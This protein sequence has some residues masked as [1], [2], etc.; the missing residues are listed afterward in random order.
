MSLTS[1]GRA[2]VALPC[3]SHGSRAPLFVSLATRNAGA[4]LP[5]V[6]FRCPVIVAMRRSV[7]WF[8]EPGA[9]WPSAYLGPS[10]S[11]DGCHDDATMTSSGQPVVTHTAALP[12]SRPD[13][14]ASCRATRRPARPSAAIP[15][16]SGSRN[17]LSPTSVAMPTIIT[18]HKE[19]DVEEK[20][21]TSNA[22]TEPSHDAA[23]PG[24]RGVP[25][26]TQS[27]STRYRTGT[28]T[29]NAPTLTETRPTS[30]PRS[31]RTHSLCVRVSTESLIGP[32]CA[33]PRNLCRA[34][35]PFTSR[36]DA[37][38]S[39]LAAQSRREPSGLRGLGSGR[40][41]ATRRSTVEE[42]RGS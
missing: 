28:I 24:S 38:T 6:H 19:S 21:S 22:I 31:R 9:V 5:T 39:R 17:S 36:Q 42:T 8:S 12:S 16:P 18:L 25:K 32:A 7:K 14:R 20:S 29:G 3:P 30:W 13:R 15:G 2:W 1:A 35:R 10:G 11:A 34:K 41:S 37:W 27:P 4:C 33:R 26:T 23:S 40:N